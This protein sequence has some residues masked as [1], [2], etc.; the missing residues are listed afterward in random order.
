MLT[1][2]LFALAA[3]LLGSSMASPVPQPGN[4]EVRPMQPSTTAIASLENLPN[5]DTGRPA[6]KAPATTSA[7]CTMIV[8]IADPWTW[9]PIRTIFTRTDTTTIGIDCGSCTAID[10]VNW[11]GV[12]PVPIFNETVTAEV[13]STLTV[14]DC[15]KPTPSPTAAATP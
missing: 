6:P 2:H 5:L 9:G 3:A 7:P 15:A 1:S 13:A 11:G 4:A 12:Q 8:P 10:F 14:Y